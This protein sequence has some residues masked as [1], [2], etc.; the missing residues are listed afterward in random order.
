MTYDSVCDQLHDSNHSGVCAIDVPYDCK[1]FKQ[2][3]FPSAFWIKIQNNSMQNNDALT[4]TIAAVILRAIIRCCMVTVTGSEHWRAFA[5]MFR[6]LTVSILLMPCVNLQVPRLTKYAIV[7]LTPLESVKLRP[8]LLAH[9]SATTV[10]M[11]VSPA[12]QVWAMLLFPP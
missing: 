6:G 8:I 11:E 12:A 1:I 7:I 3:R 5:C 10:A 9:F 4:L 2:A